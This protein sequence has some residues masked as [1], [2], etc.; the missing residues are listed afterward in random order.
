VV[1]SDQDTAKNFYVETLGWDLIVDHRAGDDFSVVQV[2]SPGW[3][4][5]IAL[6]RNAGSAWLLQGLHLVVGDIET[7]RSELSAR[8]VDAGE[9]FHF[10]DGRQAP[11]ADAE[12]RDYNTFFTFNDPGGTGWMVQEVGRRTAAPS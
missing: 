6:M 11:S 7:A 2:S 1:V 3:A 8:G 4:S 9:L 12:R 5:A 10:E